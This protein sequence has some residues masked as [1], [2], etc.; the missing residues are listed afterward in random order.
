[1]SQA[2]KRTPSVTGLRKVPP[3]PR[4]KERSQGSRNV[5]LHSPCLPGA[6]TLPDYGDER[7]SVA[8]NADVGLIG[9]GVMGQNL[10]LNLSDH[11]YSVVVY[12]RTAARTEDFISAKAGDADIVAAYSLEELVGWITPPRRII[13]MVKAGAPVN[14]VV[15]ELITLLDP[16]DVIIDGGNSHY[17]DTIRRTHAV[18]AHDLLYVGAGISGGEEGARHGPSI[19]PGGSARAWPLVKDM[20]Q[21]VA[22]RVS[23]GTPCCDWVGGDGAGH[24]VKMVHNGIEYGDMQLIAEAYQLMHA[25]LGM[26]HDEMASVFNAWNQGRLN[27]YLVEITAEILARRDHG[28]PLLDQILDAAGQKGTGRWTVAAALELGTPATLVAEAVFARILSALK[29]ERTGAS[30]VLAGPEPSIVGDRDEVVDNLEHA[31]YASKIVSYAQ[32]F[33]LLREAAT[34]HEWDLDSGSIAL[35]WREG[36]IIRAV[37]LDEIRNAFQREKDLPNLLLDPFFAEALGAAQPGWRKTVARAAEAGLP[38]PAYTSA[39]AFYDGYRSER[40]PAN[41]IQAQRDYFGAHTYERVDR[42]RGEF[43]HTDW[44]GKNGSE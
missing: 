28:E 22:A 26:S 34:A 9:L 8:G 21:A 39:L 6:I 11:G 33:A 29:E 4:G 40:L 15:T 19:M 36:C 13:V 14:A 24:F 37:F 1:M 35:L 16:G 42:P 17:L 23:D 2:G 18:E 20:L 31:L 43:H 10:A 25:G 7:G 41:L 30:A 3:S 27:S 44:T 38:I 12:N 32:G 5:A